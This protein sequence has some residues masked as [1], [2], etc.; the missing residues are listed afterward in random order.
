MRNFA[1]S[2]AIGLSGVDRSLRVRVALAF[3]LFKAGMPVI[4]L[5]VGCQLSHALGAEAPLSAG[6]CSSSRVPTP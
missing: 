3:G 6:R 4:V 5:L 1:A 2:I